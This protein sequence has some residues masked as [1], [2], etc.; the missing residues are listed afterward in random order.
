[1]S[2]RFQVKSSFALFG[3]KLSNLKKS[4]QCIQQGT[5]SEGYSRPEGLHRFWSSAGLE[6]VRMVA[7]AAHPL[8]HRLLRTDGPIM[9]YNKHYH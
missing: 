4:Y 2:K 3:F 5:G 7:D 9:N 1:M 6:P 8:P